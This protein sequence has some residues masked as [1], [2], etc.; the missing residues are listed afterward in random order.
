MKKIF[1]LLVCFWGIT[2]VNFAQ[3]SDDIKKQR[4]TSVDQATTAA[5]EVGLTEE[6]TAKLKKV[7]E[8]LFKEQ[9][10]I[11]ADTVST[12]EQKKVKLTKANEKK[13]WRIENLLG[14][15]YKAYVEARKRLIAEAASKKQ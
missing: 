11:R 5:K 15:K 2:Q 13:D 12:K 7:F 8:D 1:F 10:E 4:A 14:D 9:D 6:Q 3:T